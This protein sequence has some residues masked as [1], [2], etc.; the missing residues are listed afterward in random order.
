M[1]GPIPPEV[2]AAVIRDIKAGTLSQRQIGRD[3]G[4]SPASVGN[5]ARE[6][7]LLNAFD[8]SA[9]KIATEAMVVDNKALRVALARQLILDA[10]RFRQR[11]WKPYKTW[12]RGP[13]GLEQVEH[14]LPPAR[15]QQALMTSLGIATQRHMELEKFD[16]DGSAADEKSMIGTLFDELREIRDAGRGN[17]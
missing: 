4:I 1:P 5:I 16:R 10:E 8:R 13:E 2:R 12:E 11:A 15:E 14:E 9:T 6:A 7:G 3:H 17:T